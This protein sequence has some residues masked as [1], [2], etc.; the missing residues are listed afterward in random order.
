MK[1]VFLYAKLRQIN[2]RRDL[3]WNI[4]G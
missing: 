2:F 4:Y 3:R 1:V